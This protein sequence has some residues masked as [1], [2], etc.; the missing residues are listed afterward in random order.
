MS[1]EKVVRRGR[2]KQKNYTLERQHKDGGYRWREVGGTFV[3]N[4]YEAMR[5]EEAK[6][7]T[8]FKYPLEKI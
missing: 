2:C 7:K 1:F 4:N 6:Q 8:V 5:E 3:E